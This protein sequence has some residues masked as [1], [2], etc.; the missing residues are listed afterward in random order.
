MRSVRN[1]QERSLEM[2]SP[3]LPRAQAKQSG[4]ACVSVALDTEF[5]SLLDP[6]LLSI[7]LVVIETG[8]ECYA[9][10]DLRSDQGRQRLDVT[11]WDVREGVIGQFGLF[12]EACCDGETSMG[13]RVG[14]WLQQLTV[15]GRQRLEL[16][17]D[18]STDFELLVGALEACGLWPQ[19]RPLTAGRNVASTTG[20]TV[21]QMTR[22]RCF[23]MLRARRPPLYRHHA[24][25]DALALREAWR[26]CSSER[27][28]A[29][30]G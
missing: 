12:P 22:E 8:V 5:T 15:S 18:Y 2:T 23:Q 21:G 26:R 30:P 9:E 19:L 1:H 28:S 20:D 3:T 14:I 7:G 11:P 16:L 27:L 17:Y 25:A 13:R 29:P 4:A 10:L 24:L 6:Q